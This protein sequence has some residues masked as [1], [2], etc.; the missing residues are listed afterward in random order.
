MSERHHVCPQHD[1]A[2][3]RRLTGGEAAVVITVLVLA[4]AL[5][6]AGIPLPGVIGLL[7]A[8]GTLGAGLVALAAATPLRGVG[9]ALRA[10]LLSGPQR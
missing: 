6:L 7:A 10:A 8:A 3:V 2:V 9:R 1:C 4:S 5:A